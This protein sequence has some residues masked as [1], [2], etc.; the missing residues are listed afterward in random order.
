[1]IALKKTKELTTGLQFVD[2]TASA[3]TV[4]RAARS[5]N[6]ARG[7][8]PPRHRP[9]DNH[10]L[11]AG[12]ENWR[13]GKDAPFAVRLMEERNGTGMRQGSERQS[14]ASSSPAD[15]ARRPKSCRMQVLR[16]GF[17]NIDRGIG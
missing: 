3:A 11:P 15:G 13:D 10:G 8:F 6:P 9:I 17:G 16:H 12:K 14:I 7:D 5:A 2:Q 4:Y 1:M